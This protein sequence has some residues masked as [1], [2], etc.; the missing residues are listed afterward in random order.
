MGAAGSETRAN[1]A[2]GQI[3]VQPRQVLR[4]DSDPSNPEA[5][6][7]TITLGGGRDIAP[8]PRTRPASRSPR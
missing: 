1:L 5:G 3:A 7:L 4:C 2:A 8:V 6:Q